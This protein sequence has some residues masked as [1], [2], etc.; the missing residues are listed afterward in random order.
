MC[1]RILQNLHTPGTKSLHPKLYKGLFSS[2][3]PKS[4]P[5]SKKKIGILGASKQDHN[6]FL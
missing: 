4:D 5:V 6:L 1:V 2:E 3:I